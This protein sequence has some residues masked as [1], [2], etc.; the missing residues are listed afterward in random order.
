MLKWLRDKR[1][2]IIGATVVFAAILFVSHKQQD[3]ASKYKAHRAEYC[4]AFSPTKV[5]KE[6][7]IEEKANA[8][9]YLPWGYKLFVWPDGIATWAI[10]LTGFAIAWQ[11]SETSNAAAA[12]RDSANAAYGSV[13]FAEAQWELMKEKERA[14]FDIQSGTIITEEAD[15]SWHLIATMKT[16]N[17]G[18]SRLFIVRSSVKFTVKAQDEAHPELDAYGQIS[19]GDSFINPV[20]SFTEHKSFFWPD[21][22]DRIR[23]MSEDLEAS[24]RS[25]HLYGF[26]DYQTLGMMFRKEFGF[27]WKIIPQQWYLGGLVGNDV[28]QTDGQKIQFGYWTIDADKDK[29]EYPISRE[30]AE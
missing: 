22:E 4:A 1:F 18:Q 5:Q 11:S 2:W 7:C 12:A 26:V 24:R 15:E 13:A 21:K 25:L 29:P 3:A 20:D 6:A 14:R 10:I 30:S 19:F 16:R 9:D 28:P 23:Y 27:V 17:I 8:Q